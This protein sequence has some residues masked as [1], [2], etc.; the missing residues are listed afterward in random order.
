MEKIKLT[1]ENE[2]RFQEALK[3]YG[4]LKSEDEVEQSYREW[5]ND[6][7]GAVKIGSLE[8]DAA[9]VLENV[10]PTAYRCGLNDYIDSEE[11][12]E[13]MVDDKLCYADKDIDELRAEWWGENGGDLTNCLICGAD[14]TGG[15]LCDL[16][17][18][19]AAVVEIHKLNG[20]Y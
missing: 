8:Y 2:A 17:Q 16:C 9:L 11:L 7:S 15:S 18:E 1:A 6:L 5:L 14:I 10:D 19:R 20:C 13:I 12:Q 3:L 4:N